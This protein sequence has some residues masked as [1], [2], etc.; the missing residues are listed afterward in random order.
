MLVSISAGSGYI[1]E[2][3]ILQCRHYFFWFN[4]IAREK[5]T[6]DMQGRKTVPKEEMKAWINF[7][8]GILRKPIVVDPSGV[9]LRYCPNTI[10]SIFLATTSG[11]CLR[12]ILVITTHLADLTNTFTNNNINKRRVFVYLITHRSSV[13][14]ATAPMQNQRH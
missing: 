5:K 11:F 2:I 7:R 13:G 4:Y 3:G 6:S 12:S 14:L 10:H 9:L 8:M 1:Q